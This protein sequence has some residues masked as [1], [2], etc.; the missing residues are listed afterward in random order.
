MHAFSL[1]CPLFLGLSVTFNNVL[2][3]FIVCLF[4]LHSLTGDTRQICACVYHP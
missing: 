2:I 1:P 3:Q 4:D